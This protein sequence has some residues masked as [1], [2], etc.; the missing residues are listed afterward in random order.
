MAKG[1]HLLIKVKQIG[2]D[3][4]LTRLLAKGKFRVL[5]NPNNSIFKRVGK[6]YV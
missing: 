2:I 6:L 5:N 1:L 4:L 3:R